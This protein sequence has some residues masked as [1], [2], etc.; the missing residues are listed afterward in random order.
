MISFTVSG[1]PVGKGRPKAT[2]VGGRA[3]M[4][5]PTKTVN[6]ENKIALFAQEAGVKPIEGAVV[7]SI[8]AW[9][10]VPAADRNRKSGSRL[11][12]KP[13]TKRPDA[14]NI[15]KTVCDALNGIA[16]AD[17]CQVYKITVTKR[18]SLMPSLYIRIS[19]EDE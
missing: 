2:T 13:C 1:E 19:G 3:R 6:A 10:G 9:F 7:V 16:W 8:D 5:T 15:A 4:Y 12:G 14:D 11:V 17:D 18:W